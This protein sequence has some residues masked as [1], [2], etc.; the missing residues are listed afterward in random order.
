MYV[1]ALLSSVWKLGGLVLVHSQADSKL[2][3][4]PSLPATNPEPLPE[5]N[6]LL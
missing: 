4:Q 5:K 1:G 2:T 3:R 6:L